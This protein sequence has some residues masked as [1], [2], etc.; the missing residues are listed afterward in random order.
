MMPSSPYS[1]LSDTFNSASGIK[2]GIPL[3]FALSLDDVQYTLFG[4]YHGTDT[5]HR[6][7]VQGDTEL[8]RRSYGHF[9]TEVGIQVY[10][11]YHRCR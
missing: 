1:S 6:E 4:R 8:A 9:G 11:L 2:A 5:V 10:A 7:P 3:P